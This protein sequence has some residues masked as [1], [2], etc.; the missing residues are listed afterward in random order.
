MVHHSFE[1]LAEAK[2]FDIGRF[3]VRTPSCQQPLWAAAVGISYMAP[4]ECRG[5]RKKEGLL[6]DGLGSVLLHCL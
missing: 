1:T 3:G 6:V 2:Q 4:L 5:I